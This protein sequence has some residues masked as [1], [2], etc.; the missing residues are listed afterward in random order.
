[1]GTITPPSDIF[2]P[3]TSQVRAAWYSGSP[4]RCS[5]AETESE[6][7]VNIVTL[8][9][10]GSVEV[11]KVPLHPMHETRELRGTYDELTSLET[12]RAVGEGDYIKAVLTDED[13]VPRTP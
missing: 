9:E 13:D 7:V 11:E 1:M 2:T 8:G 4:V 5:F 12:R 3:R 6:K 10:K